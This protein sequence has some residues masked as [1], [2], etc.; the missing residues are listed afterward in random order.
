MSVGISPVDIYNIDGYKGSSESSLNLWLLCKA[1]VKLTE[2][3]QDGN[4]YN[5]LNKQ[6]QEMKDK[7]SPINDC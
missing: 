7:N 2:L 1:L 5:R 4:P 6:F 3:Y